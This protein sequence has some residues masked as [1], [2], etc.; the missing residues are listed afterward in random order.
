MWDNVKNENHVTVHEEATG[1]AGSLHHK[2]FLPF[3]LYQ[4]RGNSGPST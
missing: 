2:G 3:G 1:P 4:N